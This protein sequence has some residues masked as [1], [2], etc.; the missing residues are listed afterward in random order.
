MDNIISHIGEDFITLFLDG[1]DKCFNDFLKDPLKFA[2]FELNVKKS[3]DALGRQMIKVGLE[4]IN[5]YFKRSA[6]RV[7]DWYVERND[8]K[9]LTTTFG[10]VTYVK[11]LFRHKTK[12]TDDGKEIMCYLVDKVVGMTPGQRVSDAAHAMVYAEAAQTSYRR[13]GESF[14]DTAGIS[15]QAVM[16]ILHS[17][18]FPIDYEAPKERKKLKYL[19]IDADEDHISLQYNEERGD[20][21]KGPTGRKNNGAM[22]KLVYIYEGIEKVSPESKRHRLVNPHYFCE[23]EEDDIWG[24]VYSYILDT[25]DIS[26][27]KVIYINAD[28]GAWIKSGMKQIAGARYVLDG[29]HLSKYMG[30]MTAHMMDSAY[31][32]KVQLCDEIKQGNKDSF[33]AKAKEIASYSEDQKI[34]E[35]VL[36]AAGYILS[37]WMAAKR[38][39]E[40]KDGVAACSAE[41]H[42]SHVLACR[43]STPAL[44]WCRHGADVMAHLRA[45]YLNKGN[46]L[47]LV[48]YQKR[49]L[50]KAAGAEDIAYSVSDAIRD[51]TDHRS[52]V[53][54]M[55]GKYS[56]SMGGTIVGLSDWFRDALINGGHMS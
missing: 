32:A 47:E 44:A 15:K 54:Q 34:Q 3:V 21:V 38:R 12:K 40:H 26:Q 22:T 27:V 17:T 39:L 13:A 51:S 45:Y 24:R 4:A 55:I 6:D 49:E 8:M 50:P 36:A 42:V 33:I 20:L 46:L 10:D 25:Y 23:V 37:N 5:S 19:Y 53:Q 35:A 7:R 14:S 56:S 2:Q 18:D 48:R 1:L 41:G 30:K 43:M 11:T 28:G 9:Q 16:D 31:D 52:K 29:F